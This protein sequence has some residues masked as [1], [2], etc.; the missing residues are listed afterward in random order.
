MSL[1]VLYVIYKYCIVKL[2]WRVFLFNFKI[3]GFIVVRKS[4][5]LKIDGK[6]RGLG[7]DL[8]VKALDSQSRGPVF[9]TTG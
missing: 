7:A 8:V 5:L 4:L 3:C 1:I 6:A 2:Y 9:K